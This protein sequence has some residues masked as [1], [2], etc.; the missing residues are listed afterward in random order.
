MSAATKFFAESIARGEVLLN[1][2]SP[3]QS[4][5]K[6]PCVYEIVDEVGRRM[7]VGVTTKLRAAAYYNRRADRLPVGRTGD[8]CGVGARDEG[9]GEECGGEVL[10]SAAAKCFAESVARGDALLTKRSPMQPVCKKP[11]VYEIVDEVGRRMFVGVTAKLRAAA[12]YNRRAD[13]LRDGRAMRVVSEH[14]TKEEAMSAAAKCFAESVVRGDALLNKCSP[15]QRVCK[16][17]C[18]YEIVDEA[19]RRVFV[20]ATTSWRS[21]VDR[22]R[23]C[24]RLRAKRSMRVVSEHETKE[25]AKS[26]AAKCWAESVARGDALLN[27]LSPTQRCPKKPCVYEI[28]DEAGRR[29]F[30]GATTSWRSA[31]DLLTT[32][33]KGCCS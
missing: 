28:V 10:V 25:E 24:G 16:K 33:G 13:R 2:L 23:S 8:A 27:K 18:V 7:F 22:H 6:K 30:V 1:K 3:R 12:Y 15:M 20:G 11:C 5:P 31:V 19:G 21:A 4:A 9:G 14:E 32:Q 17:P 29:V 26:A